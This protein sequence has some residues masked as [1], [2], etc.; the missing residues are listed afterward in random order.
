MDLDSFLI[1]KIRI[2]GGEGYKKVKTKLGPLFRDKFFGAPYKLGGRSKEEGFDCFSLIY[3]F[4]EQCGFDMPEGIDGVSATD[5]VDLWNKDEEDAKRVMWNYINAFT[6][7][8]PMGKMLPGDITVFRTPDDDIY[9]GIYVGN[10]MVAVATSDEGVVVNRLET[11]KLF[12]VRRW[13]N[14]G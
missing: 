1:W 14:N 13:V 4:H 2:S 10:N 9:P 12:A 3:C 5:Y 7:P 8:V 6:K 11:F